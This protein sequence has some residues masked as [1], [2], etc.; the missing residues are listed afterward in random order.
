MPGRF[1]GDGYQCLG[2]ADDDHNH[3]FVIVK[4]VELWPIGNLYGDGYLRTRCSAGWGDDHVFTGT[5]SDRDFAVERREGDVFDLEFS[6]G[7]LQH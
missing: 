2:G 7:Q 1:A 3:D 4:S 5:E 6:G